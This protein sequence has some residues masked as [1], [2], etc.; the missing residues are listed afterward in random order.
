MFRRRACGG[1]L[2]RG[3]AEKAR[4]TLQTYVSQLRK[5]I[6][7]DRIQGQTPG[8]RLRL[9]PRELDAERFDKLIADARKARAMAPGVVVSLLDEA[10]ELWRGPALSDVAGEGSLLAEAARLNELKLV[11]SEERIDALL[12][13]GEHG[14]VIGQIEALVSHDPLREQLWGQLMLALYR[15]G[16][17][18][19]ALNA[20]Q[21]ARETLADELGI[22]PSP[23]LSRLQE[24]MLKQDPA[25]EL[26]G[27]PLRGYRLLEK[28][29]EGTVGTIF[30]A[31][32]P[33]VGRDVVVKVIN[34]SIA[35]NPG[36]IRRFEQEAQSV[37]ALEH[38]HLVPVYDY[39][40]EPSGAYLVSRYLRGGNLRALQ[41]RGGLETAQRA[42]I[43]GQVCAALAFAHRQGVAHGNVKASDVLLDAEG[44]AYLGDFRIGAGPPPDPEEDVRGLA[45]L[46]QGLFAA[47]M[48]RHLAE[49]TERAEVG[50]DAPTADEF[51]EA[52]RMAFEPT[53]DR[54]PAVD[55]RNPYKGLRPFTEADATDFFGRGALV[56]RVL[57]RMKEAAPE[58]GSSPWWARAGAGSR[59]WLAPE[60]FRPS[61]GEL[62]S[63]LR[64]I[65]S[66]P[67][68]SLDRTRSMSSRR[69]SCVSP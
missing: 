63:R 43:L 9:E 64:R 20:Y 47:D 44:N 12:A 42:R 22:D 7:H 26:R 13:I 32:Q 57:G 31:I 1:D 29:D 38:P 6:G 54:L 45:R 46:V 62:S 53:V 16:R 51:A 40:R 5:A 30:R 15:E 28:I 58:R 65:S 39:W 10:L 11:A 33:H 25:L 60:S 41:E 18:A 61:G 49:L 52:A 34:E 14:R 37:A 69:R 50:A 48:P 3:P 56:K 35:A 59:Q 55:A 36:F 2:G 24:R 68:C 17:Q 19:D 21:R 23:E 27:E 66:S 67:R 8:Y 4:N